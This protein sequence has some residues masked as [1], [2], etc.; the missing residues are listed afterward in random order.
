MAL[1]LNTI[2]FRTQLHTCWLSPIP[3][4]FATVIGGFRLAAG[5]G[6][7]IVLA[8]GNDAQHRGQSQWL[9]E[10]DPG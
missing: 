7:D 10:G 4:A 6:S 1:T 5:R 2:R 3:S 8:E 9:K